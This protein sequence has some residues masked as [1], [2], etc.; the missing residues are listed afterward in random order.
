MPGEKFWEEVLNE[1]HTGPV[2]LP[3]PGLYYILE[4][5]AGVYVKEGKF[6]E[7]QGGLTED[8]G[9][10]W[11]PVNADSIEHAKSMGKKKSEKI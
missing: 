2:S 5:H 1:L 3:G 8:W 7:S 4:T 9:K 10:N 11:R 6:F